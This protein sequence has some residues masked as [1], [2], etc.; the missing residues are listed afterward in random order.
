MADLVL[1][2][3][4]RFVVLYDLVALVND[5]VTGESAL[6]SAVHLSPDVVNELLS[7]MLAQGFVKTARSDS[8]F[9]ITTLGSNF[10]QEFQGMRRFLS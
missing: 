10:L 1:E 3:Y 2:A 7:F 8:E 9:R 5:D 6:A 4:D